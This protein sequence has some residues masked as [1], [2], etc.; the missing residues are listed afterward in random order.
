SQDVSA[1]SCVGYNSCIINATAVSSEPMPGDDGRGGPKPGRPLTA[2][3]RSDKGAGMRIMIEEPAPSEGRAIGQGL[4][5]HAR[6]SGVEPRHHRPLAVLLRDGD[7]RVVGGLTGTTVWGWLQ[8]TL[9]WVDAALR[10]R[11]HGT[12][13]LRVA[14]AEAIRRGCHHAWLD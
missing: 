9:V 7:G 5:E 14:E 13:L 11:R 2:R 3:G 6:G 1:I 8:V 10:R 12:A 4:I